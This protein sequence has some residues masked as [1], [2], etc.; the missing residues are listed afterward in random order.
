MVILPYPYPFHTSSNIC[1]LFVFIGVN[2]QNWNFSCWPLDVAEHQAIPQ[3]APSATVRARMQQARREANKKKTTTKSLKV[4]INIMTQISVQPATCRQEK[5][6]RAVP[7]VF[8]MEK[9]LYFHPNICKRE[10][11][12]VPSSSSCYVPFN[13]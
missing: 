3:K 4:T 12:S 13:Q 10:L 8:S 7:N 5:L 9:K 6:T 2:K 1:R 11:K